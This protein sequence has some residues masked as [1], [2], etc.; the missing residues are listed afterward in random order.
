MLARLRQT[1]IVF[2]NI[3]SWLFETLLEC[4]FTVYTPSSMLNARSIMSDTQSFTVNNGWR[5]RYNK[6]NTDLICEA[7]SD[8]KQ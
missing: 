4:V 2:N 5:S 8:S 3:L 1:H 7:F 6:E